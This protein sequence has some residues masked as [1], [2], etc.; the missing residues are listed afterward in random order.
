MRHLLRSRRWRLA[1]FTVF[2]PYVLM[3]VLVDAIH[4]APAGTTGRAQVRVD[5]SRV[6]EHGSDTTPI[7]T[8]LCPACGWLRAGTSSSPVITLLVTTDTVR[9]PRILPDVEWP[10]SPV[11]N[12]TA[13][14]GPPLLG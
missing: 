5:A 10:D 13:F 3:A 8:R 12:P 14:R 4:V 7:D 6:L 1:V 9:V 2:L 11:P